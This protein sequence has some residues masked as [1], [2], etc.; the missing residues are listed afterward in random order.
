MGKNRFVSSFLPPPAYLNSTLI[1]SYPLL[2]S[3]GFLINAI[4]C[5]ISYQPYVFLYPSSFEYCLDGFWNWFWFVDLET[6]NFWRA[7]FLC[8]TLCPSSVLCRSPPLSLNPLR[9][10]MHR[11]F[12]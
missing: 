12:S 2:V 8:S 10:R 1:C 9:F 6:A 11:F 5:P 7:G 3:K 4:L